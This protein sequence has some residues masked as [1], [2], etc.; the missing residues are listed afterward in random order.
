VLGEHVRSFC[1]R[2]ASTCFGALRKRSF[3]I[4]AF[5]SSDPILGGTNFSSHNRIA[6]RLNNADFLR[7]TFSKFDSV[8]VSL[9]KGRLGNHTP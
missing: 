6:L 9:G 1:I 2:L 3:A 8:M 7:S 5:R 4:Q